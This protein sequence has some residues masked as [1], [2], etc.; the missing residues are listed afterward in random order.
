M[1]GNRKSK[2][3]YILMLAGFFLFSFLNQPIQ[4]FSFL[5]LSLILCPLSTSHPFSDELLILL[6]KEKREGEAKG[7][8]ERE[9]R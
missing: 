4:M 7:E 5:S 9:S 6:E 3:K 8:R 1:P 2:N